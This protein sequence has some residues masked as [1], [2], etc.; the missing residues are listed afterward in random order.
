MMQFCVVIFIL[1]SSTVANGRWIGAL[2]RDDGSSRYR[3]F[4]PVVQDDKVRNAMVRM[5]GEDLNKDRDELTCPIFFWLSQTPY[6]LY[7]DEMESDHDSE[8]N[9]HPYHVKY[10]DN[11]GRD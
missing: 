1:L 3:K 11:W 7:R 10:I 5:H 9:E 2:T 6:E 4:I 8:E